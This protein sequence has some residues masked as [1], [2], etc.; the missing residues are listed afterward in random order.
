MSKTRS[1]RAGRGIS[2]GM[3][4]SGGPIKTQ[5]AEII[6]AILAAAVLTDGIARNVFPSGINPVVQ[7]H[8]H[9]LGQVVSIAKKPRMAT[10]PA[11]HG[12]TFIVYRPMQELR[13]E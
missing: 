5:S 1:R 2:V 8:L 10:D 7:I 12:R 13:P 6:R 9:Q 4:R 3:S 11:Q